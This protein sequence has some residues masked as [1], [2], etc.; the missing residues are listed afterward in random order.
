LALPA[1][2][3]FHA[4][5]SIENSNSVQQTLTL[6]VTLRPMN[7][8][9]APV[10]QVFKESLAPQ[11]TLAVATKNF[12][13]QPGERA[14]LLITVSGAPIGTGLSKARTYHVVLSP[15]GHH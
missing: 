6:A 10:R 11:Q 7:G 4:M 9:L 13:T 3:K 14:D 2:H 12:T 1:I 15:S 8:S 5:V